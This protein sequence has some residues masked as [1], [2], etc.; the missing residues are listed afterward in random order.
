LIFYRAAEVVVELHAGRAARRRLDA[1][2]ADVLSPRDE[3]D[4]APLDAK[5]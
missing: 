5:D 4:A 1:T 3:E 2:H